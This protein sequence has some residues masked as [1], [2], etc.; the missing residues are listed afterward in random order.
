M[1][2]R[3]FIVVLLALSLIA[4]LAI[5]AAYVHYP[6]IPHDFKYYIGGAEFLL[7]GE[8]LYQAPEGHNLIYC[9]GPLTAAV[10]AAWIYLF[11]ADYFLFKIPS[12]LFDLMATVA[13][14]LLA[15]EIKPGRARHIAILYAFSYPALAN[16]ALTGNDDCF[17]FL[18]TVL[19]AY[20]LIRQN[21]TFS[22][23]LMGTAL[24]FKSV[25]LVFIPP[26]LWYLHRKDRTRHILRF[27]SA[28]LATFAII[29]GVFY[30]HG[31]DAI[32]P[33]TI[34][35]EARIGLLEPLNLL[36][37]TAGA[38][39]N[40]IHYLNTGETIPLAENPLKSSVKHPINEFFNS[41]STPS[42]ILGFALAALYGIKSKKKNVEKE[43]MRNIYLV[44][45]VVMFF[46][47]VFDDLYL[48]WFTPFILIL[49]ETKKSNI[50]VGATATFTGLMLFS[51]IYRWNSDLVILERLL[52]MAAIMLIPV[53]TYLMI[54][55]KALAMTVLAGMMFRQTLANHLL[56]LI[57]DELVSLSIYR[58]ATMVLM[59]AAIIILFKEVHDADYSA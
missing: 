40:A 16:S 28:F 31:H 43:L 54:R 55:S 4:R 13:V 37:L 41:M 57:G 46:G 52:L 25:A 48:L 49:L 26:M 11:G 22:G 45:A 27:L 3:K 50:P 5:G 21:T 10:H 29:M 19:A 2:D 44:S 32:Y 18:F 34:T 12:I 58:Y 36:R 56:P 53:G 14:F 24:G 59:T 15:R 33:Y 42:L 39:E 38:V 51:L 30:L 17:F 6:D 8:Q 9:Y 20:A 7:K 47:I 35:H 1:D 23:I